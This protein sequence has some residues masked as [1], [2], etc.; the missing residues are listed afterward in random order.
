MAKN[1]VL[2]DNLAEPLNGI[3]VA[4]VNI[5]AGDGNLTIDRITGSEQLL[6][7]GTLQYLE[8]RGQPT[9]SLVSRN[10][11]ATLTLLGGTRQRWFRLPWAACNGATEWQIH[12]NPTVS[13]D[14]TAHSDGGNLKLDLTGMAVTSVSADT[15]GGNVDVVLP[16]NAANL[17]V[18]AKTGAG[19]VVVRIPSGVAARIRATTGMGKVTIAPRFNKTADNIYES[20]DFDG[21]ANRV[22]ITLNSGAGS[23]TVN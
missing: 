3:T 19:A 11:Q 4:K 17:N 9:Q 7:S 18:T 15:G 22:D 2:T 10:G 1:D 20:S 16:N 12:L 6:V 13:S 21:A 14:I 8:K 5:N 23:V